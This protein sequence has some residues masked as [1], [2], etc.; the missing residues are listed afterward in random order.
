MSS[1]TIRARRRCVPVHNLAN[2]Q[3]PSDQI[4]ELA[5]SVKG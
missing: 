3:R 4:M 2:Q 1:R 5:G